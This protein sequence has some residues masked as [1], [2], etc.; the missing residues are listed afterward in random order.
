M[1]HGFPGSGISTTENISA[2][3]RSYGITFPTFIAYSELDEAIES[4][5]NLNLRD[6]KGALN[7]KSSG[8]SF[9]DGGDEG[10]L[11]EDNGANDLGL[12]CY[13]GAF[14]PSQGHP[15]YLDRKSVV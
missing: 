12:T 7:M 1:V 15:Y 9:V 11:C 8:N 3:N 6:G 13:N 2:F 10:S 4:Y 5:P 14:E